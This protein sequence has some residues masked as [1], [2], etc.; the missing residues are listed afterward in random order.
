MTVWGGPN[1]ANYRVRAPGRSSGGTAEN[2]SRQRATN[3]DVTVD[4][5][6]NG[7]NTG[8]HGVAEPQPKL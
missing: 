7:I 3:R 4:A 5:P 8:L 2:V 1:A 6:G